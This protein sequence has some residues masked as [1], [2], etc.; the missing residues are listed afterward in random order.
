MQEAQNRSHLPRAWELLQE[1]DDEGNPRG[2]LPYTEAAIAELTLAHECDPE[3]SR[4]T[5]HLAI[6][7]H[8]R[9]WD[10]E[11]AGDPRAVPEW[12]R[13][14]GFWYRLAAAPDFWAGLAAK[15]RRCSEQADP[16][17]VEQARRDL[18]GDLLDIHVAFVRL[19]SESDEHARAV[20][21]VE[22]VK[23]AR[24]PLAA[25]R[26]LVESVYEAMTAGIAQAAAAHNFDTGLSIL[27]RFLG[28]FPDYLPALRRYVELC[29]GALAGL[30]CLDAWP[31]IEELCRRAESG[32]TSLAQHP[33]LGDDPLASAALVEFTTALLRKCY[34]RAQSASEQRERVRAAADLGICC[35][36]LALPH[37]PLDSGLR[38]LVGGCLFQRVGVCLNEY[39]ETSGAAVDEQTRLRAMRNLLVEAR[40]YLEEGLVV[41]PDDVTVKETLAA[42]QGELDARESQIARLGL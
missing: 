5:H 26:R 13:A 24:I 37:S 36:R 25:R 9:A 19:Y 6:A 35:G 40:G 3:D 32:L 38:S 10:M 33:E 12:E 1:R 29:T 8:A 41:E 42:V 30:S 21:H 11:L 2:A 23:R 22:I 14:L 15:L 18:L 17:V 20:A 34:E 27:E 28:L 39:A 7:H 4:V 16:A 31:A